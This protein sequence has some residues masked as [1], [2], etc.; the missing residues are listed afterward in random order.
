MFTLAGIQTAAALSVVREVCGADMLSEFCAA[1][2]VRDSSISTYKAALRAFGRHLA[3]QGICAPQRADIESFEA[4]LRTAGARDTTIALYMTALRRFFAWLAARGIYADI[5]SGYKPVER[6]D[7]QVHRKDALS[8]ADMRIILESID[9]S[10]LKG[11]RDYALIVLAVVGALRT[12]ELSRATV[13]SLQ[14]IGG[15]PALRVHG[16]GRSTDNDFVRISETAAKAV[17]EYLA[18]R[19]ACASDDS[20]FV[21]L[22]RGRVGKCLEARR[23][24][25][26]IKQRLRAAGYDSD[27]LTAHSLRHT[28][29]TLALQG[30]ATL[31]QVKVYAR[32]SNVQTTLIYVHG[33]DKASNVCGATVS[34]EIFGG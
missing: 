27:R 20:L 23:I 19:G 24:S 8:A 33:L 9:R 29:V 13:G 2:R 30:G 5:A 15:A 11:K 7:R 21:S 4:A 18:M 14:T 26:I 12:I 3:A 32:H 34:N 25:E 10:T 17:R 22:K 31:E 28:G 16:K 1:L 6:V